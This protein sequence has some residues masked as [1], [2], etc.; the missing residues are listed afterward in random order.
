MQQQGELGFKIDE[1]A[2]YSPRDL[3]L[4][5]GISQDAQDHERRSGRLPH[6]IVGGQYNQTIVYRGKDLI[7]WLSKSGLG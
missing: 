5:L 2:H 1:N 3:Q 4:G 6:A 7:G